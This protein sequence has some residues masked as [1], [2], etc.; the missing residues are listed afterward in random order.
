[1][2]S[3][4]AEERWLDASGSSM[5][6]APFIWVNPELTTEPTT[7]LTAVT[8]EV[9]CD[10]TNPQE[11][12]LVHT[13]SKSSTETTHD[14][15]TGDQPDIDDAANDDEKSGANDEKTLLVESNKQPL[16]QEAVIVEHQ[17]NEILEGDDA[18]LRRIGT[19]AKM[20]G[21]RKKMGEKLEEKRRNIEEKG[22]HIVEKMRGPG[23]GGI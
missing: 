5:K 6:A 23:T 7:E 12:P 2:G 21:L 18:K 15:S 11:P 9:H 3:E 13:S 22:R 17:N 1:M 4:A 14:K 10:D 19:R 16:D 20:L 8:Q